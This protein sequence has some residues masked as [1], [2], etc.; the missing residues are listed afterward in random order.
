MSER[1]EGKKQ[2]LPP[3]ANC[4]AEW[5]GLQVPGRRHR[6]K[7]QVPPLPPTSDLKMDA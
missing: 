6:L 1:V 5:R 4:Q 7:P 2:T 3:I